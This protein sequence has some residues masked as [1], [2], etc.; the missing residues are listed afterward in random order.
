MP[1]FSK[2]I[3]ALSRS[4][5]VLVDELGE[6]SER[7]GKNIYRFDVG[8]PGVAPPAWAVEPLIE[9]LRRG[10]TSVYS[11]SPGP[12]LEELREAIA[13]DLRAM[14]GPRVSPDEVLVVS[15]GQHAMF[16]AL[17]SILDRGC[18]VVVTDPV[19][20]GYP[21]LIEYFG[22]SIRRVP[23][24]PGKGFK[25]NVEALSSVVRRGRTRALVIV[26]PDNPTGRVLDKSEARAVIDV[27]ASAD[28]WVLVDEAYMTLVYEGGKEWL[29]DMDPS[30][31]VGLFTFSKDPGIP[32]WR[33]GFIYG[34]REFIEKAS[35][36]ARETMYSPPMPAQLL[37]LKYLTD[38]RRKEFVE[39]ARRTYRARRDAMVSALSS[40]RSVQAYKP[41]GSIFVMADFSEYLE[42]LGTDSQGLARTL[43]DK[44]GV[45]TVPGSFFGETTKTHL[46]L[47]F[48]GEAEERIKEGVE[49]V[50]EFL[51]QL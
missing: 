25:I 21:S 30:R 20:F 28:S 38:P 35:L 39:E 44:V 36:V 42:R 41:R 31:V 5:T 4:F 48:A 18:E 22:C 29:F 8:V 46:R 47:S 26:D 16:V 9:A 45:A 51:D 40:I 6:K 17:A 12:G 49:A 23:T 27:A 19:Y 7:A 1:L 14:K 24:D 11:Y 32:G 34:A 3:R 10:D 13:L 33:L 15:G 2:G 37:V 43:L 50:K